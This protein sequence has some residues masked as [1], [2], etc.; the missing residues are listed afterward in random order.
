MERWVHIA[1]GR[2]LSS[3]SKIP[4]CLLGRDLAQPR[5]TRNRS[6]VENVGHRARGL[7]ETQQNKRQRPDA[8][9]H[10]WDVTDTRHVARKRRRWVWLD[11]PGTKGGDRERGAGRDARPESPGLVLCI[12]KSCGCA[13]DIPYAPSTSRHLTAHP[14]IPSHFVLNASG[15]QSTELNLP[16]PTPKPQPRPPG[17]PAHPPS[18]RLKG[19]HKQTKQERCRE[20]AGGNGGAPAADEA[21]SAVQ[22]SVLRRMT[23]QSTAAVGS[24]RTGKRRKTV[25]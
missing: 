20:M 3:F 6:V 19:P 18:N 1:I 9:R 22:P 2:V 7:Q 11:V 4:D 5:P 14:Q 10:V 21:S 17:L 16:N 24:E 8:H 15:V 13:V 25:G 12:A 23:R